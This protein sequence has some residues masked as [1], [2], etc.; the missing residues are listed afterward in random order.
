MA[1]HLDDTMLCCVPSQIQLSVGV[2]K[3]SKSRRSLRI[4][5]GANRASMVLG[6]IIDMTDDVGGCLVETLTRMLWRSQK[7]ECQ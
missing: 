3:L 7:I 4:S 2:S 6:H 1:Y 5:S